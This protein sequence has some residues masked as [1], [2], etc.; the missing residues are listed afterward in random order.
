V[1]QN[2]EGAALVK[3][4]FIRYIVCGCVSLLVVFH[5]LFVQLSISNFN[6]D[7]L[8]A[9]PIAKEA[10]YQGLYSQYDLL[11]SSGMRGPFHIYKLAGLLYKYHFDVEAI[12]FTL[13]LLFVF[14]T[15]VMMWQITYTISE[16]IVI[17]SIVTILFALATP[18]TGTLNWTFLPTLTLVTSLVALPFAL[19]ALNFLLQEKYMLAMYVSALTF[20]IH[21][22]AIIIWLATA[23][24]LIF[25]VR[26][27]TLRQKFYI[28]SGSLLILLP[29]AVYTLLALPSNFSTTNEQFYTIFRNFAYHVFIEDHFR[30]G[31][32]WFFLNLGGTVFFLRYLSVKKQQTIRLILAVLLMIIV[33]Y[34]FNAYFLHYKA[35][36]LLFL[37]RATYFIKPIMFSVMLFGLCSWISQ[38]KQQ[39]SYVILGAF[40]VSF[41]LSDFRMSE[42]ILLGSYGLLLFSIT[43]KDNPSVRHFSY[44]LISTSIIEV[45]LMFG[46][47][48]VLTDVFT[49]IFIWMHIVLGCGI[50]L[51]FWR[52]Y[53]IV[54]PENKFIPIHK[55]LVVFVLILLGM[56][57]RN[58]YRTVRGLSSQI[59]LVQSSI[60]FASPRTADGVA[61]TEWVRGHTKQGAFFLI[62]PIDQTGDAL[63]FLQFRLTTERGV[64][65]SVHDINQLAY[66]AG[67]YAE[68]VGRL[69]KIGVKIVRR[70]EYNMSGYYQLSTEN[71]QELHNIDHVDYAV[72]EKD[73]VI[74][75]VKF[76]RVY[77]NNSYVIVAL[78]DKI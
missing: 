8:M 27:I 26:S 68:G 51:Y 28:L 76:S 1:G 7:I 69:E 74:K 70:H 66:D 24:Y 19:L 10:A 5:L 46:H 4:R 59:K 61:M 65:S 29:N 67:T 71:L 18:G 11:V 30:E 31:Y 23:V 42:A 75:S 37:F 3:Q 58:Y 62:P 36:L 77:E 34:I 49:T 56:Q 52:S 40:F 53:E 73:K 38:S 63:T 64:F 60:R 35:L 55:I 16:N 17:S 25:S 54:K 20:N 32:G 6:G 39:I 41:F 2:D 21:P 22:L 44:L 72:L 57:S 14:L 78:G 13:T 15:F 33:I 12:W 45:V 47:I 9:F 48:V 50:F 43:K